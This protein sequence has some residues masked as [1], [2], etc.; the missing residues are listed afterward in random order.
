M[1]VAAAGLSAR[2]PSRRPASWSITSLIRTAE[3]CDSSDHRHP[4][5][6][7]YTDSV[8]SLRFE[9]SAAN[10]DALLGELWTVHQQVVDDWIDPD[11]Y[12]LSPVI[13]R[14]RLS[15]R[16]GRL[17]RGPRF[18]VRRYAGVLRRAGLRPVQASSARGASKGHAKVLH[19]GHS[20]VVARRFRAER[21]RD[22]AG[23]QTFA[24][25]GGWR[26]NESPRLKCSR[27]PD[28]HVGTYPESRRYGVGPRWRAI[29]GRS[30]VV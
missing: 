20:F 26:E 1:P 19:F 10:V 5:A 24:A 22:H 7:Q 30:L 2:G 16:R 8:E 29:S 12:L 18:L 25:V 21:D 9:G 6:R 14:R 27:Y 13:I 3:D 17:C 15:R 28:V 4:A 11:R 23:R